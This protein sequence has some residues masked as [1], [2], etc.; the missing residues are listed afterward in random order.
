MLMPFEFLVPAL[1]SRGRDRCLL[2]DFVEV[3]SRF[4]VA[5]RF[6]VINGARYLNDG[7]PRSLPSTAKN[8][9]STIPFGLIQV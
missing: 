7:V 3:P 2:L 6:V 9:C 1:T 5:M 8:T 4:M